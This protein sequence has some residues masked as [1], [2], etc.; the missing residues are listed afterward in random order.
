MERVMVV[1]V[2]APRG[3]GAEIARRIV[4]KRLAACVN[5]VSGVKSVY[6]WQGRI[7][8]SEE[9]LLVLKTSESRIDELISFIKSIHPYEVP[10]VIA[11]P[12]E[13]GLGEY[14]AWVLNETRQG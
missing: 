14:L 1:F 5:V 2:T 13:K 10:E 6:W 12:V 4:E 8:D 11:F 7:E 3:K 9:D